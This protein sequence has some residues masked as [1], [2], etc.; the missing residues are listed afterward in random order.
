MHLLFTCLLYPHWYTDYSLVFSVSSPANNVGYSFRV[1]LA[2]P[3]APTGADGELPQK[4]DV[5]LSVVVETPGSGLV[6]TVSRAWHFSCKE[7]QDCLIQAL[8]LNDMYLPR[9][10]TL[11]IIES[12]Q[13]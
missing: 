10:T 12:M 5:Q 11:I 6:I 7:K 1:T 9:I 3:W 4:S 2:S 8:Y 13:K